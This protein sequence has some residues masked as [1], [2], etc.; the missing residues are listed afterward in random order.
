MIV[1]DASVIV[2]AYFEK[3]KFNKAAKNFFN[4]FTAKQETALIPEI[5]LV[6]IASAIARGAKNPNYAINFC[7][8]LRKF[9]NFLYIP[10]DESLSKL[11]VQIA[12]KFYLRGADAI[13]TALAYK[14]QA[15][16]ATLDL[17]QKEKSSKIIKIIEV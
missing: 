6:E 2:A 1:I 15:G 3:E 16:L 9:P 12:G 10:I 17:E 4:K 11:A 5:A 14:Y 8:E 13:Y 7:E